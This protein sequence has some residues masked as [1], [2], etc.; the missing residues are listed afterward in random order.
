MGIDHG[1]YAHWRLPKSGITML[2]KALVTGL[3]SVQTLSVR[4]RDITCVGNVV[5]NVPDHIGPNQASCF[6]CR[7]TSKKQHFVCYPTHKISNA[8]QAQ[9]QCISIS[10]LFLAVL[11]PLV[12]V[13]HC[14]RLLPAVGTWPLH[15]HVAV[16]CIM[17]SAPSPGHGDTMQWQRGLP[18][19]S[20]AGK[21][22]SGLGRWRP[23][24][25]S[26]EVLLGDLMG[27]LQM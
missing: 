14:C 25:G 4:I 22:S 8:K 26:N 18:L 9:T 12:K 17:F 19:V 3:I 13:Q 20:V 1:N 6:Q 23:S 5:T 27:I 24:R 16:A 15:S 2:C 21:V 10:L 11:K 7:F